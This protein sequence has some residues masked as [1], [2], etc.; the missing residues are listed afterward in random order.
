MVIF[1]MYIVHYLLY[2]IRKRVINF[3]KLNDIDYQ[4]KS[5][6]GKVNILTITIRWRDKI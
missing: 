3:S 6:A 1:I 4:V 5:Q 2:S